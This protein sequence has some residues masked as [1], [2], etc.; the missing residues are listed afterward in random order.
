MNSP[1]IT[2][3]IVLYVFAL[4]VL[5]FGAYCAGIGQTQFLWPAL[6][7]GVGT[8]LGTVIHWGN[9]GNGFG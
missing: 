4:L 3:R 1:K 5:A 6:V 7:L 9:C 2:W 8:I